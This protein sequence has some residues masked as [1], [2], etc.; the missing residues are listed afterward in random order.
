MDS[1]T[2]F[3]QSGLASLR[4]PAIVAALASVGIHALFAFNIEK[5]RLFPNSAQ[6][7]PS[8]ELMELSPDQVSGIY[9]PPPP[10]FSLSPVTP[11]PSLSSILGGPTVPEFPSSPPPPSSPTFTTPPPEIFTIPANP[12]VGSRGTNLPPVVESYPDTY[13]LET[14][15]PSSNIPTYIPPSPPSIPE[16]NI[17]DTI[18]DKNS[19]ELDRA[20][21]FY[22]QL[23]QGD[24]VFSENPEPLGQSGI[25]NPPRTS[26]D[27]PGNEPPRFPQKGPNDD[28]ASA[29]ID[30]EPP[31]QTPPEEFRG[32]LLAK[33]EEGL[34]QEEK[35]E[36]DGEV[37]ANSQSGGPVFRQ[38]PE[39]LREGEV[40]NQERASIQGANTY[41]N[42]VLGV[43][44]SY[45]DVEGSQPISISD[46]YP[47]E[48]CEQQ[49]SGR[50]L[51]GVVVGSGGEILAGPELLLNTGYPVLDNE[52]VQTV[53]EFVTT[54]ALGGGTPTAY[55]YAF[56]FNGENCGEASSPEQAAPETAQPAQD[57]STPAVTE[58]QEVLEDSVVEPSPDVSETE[59]LEEELEQPEAVVEPSQELEQPEA[60]V[61]PPQELEQPE[62]VGEPSQELEQPEAV[63]E[64]SEVTQ[65]EEAVVEPPEVTQPEAVI[66]PLEEVL[67]TQPPEVQPEAMPSEVGEPLENVTPAES[68]ELMN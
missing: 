46:V 3:I 31:S 68:E 59:T 67:E 5:I 64:P 8:V 11:P 26:D 32:S 16:E 30:R 19:E 53:R 61:E 45:P 10:Q 20:R 40:S 1:S 42:W 47:V 39:Q 55:Q 37:A 7:P 60:V 65:P 27:E 24:I 66:E 34:D 12:S 15:P 52:A 41:V 9:P 13:S 6:L 49:L 62:A 43:Q 28:L 17:P 35:P 58:P 22:E 38:Q 4:Q 51:V 18:P 14:L 23:Q 2:P 57:N 48:A 29:N 63:V 44:Q 33:L 21:E 36:E 54:Q 25:F 56:N 50:A